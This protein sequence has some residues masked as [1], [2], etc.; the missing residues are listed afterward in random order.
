MDNVLISQ[1]LGKYDL[2]CIEYL[3]REIYTFGK[4]FKEAT[5]SCGPL[6]CLLHEAE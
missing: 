6:N 4:C 2:I 1:S 3:V 5:A